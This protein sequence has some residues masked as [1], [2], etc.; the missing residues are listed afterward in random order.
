MGILGCS[1]CNQV[2]FYIGSFV[3]LHRGHEHIDFFLL[4]VTLT[5]CVRGN[6]FITMWD[7]LLSI[8]P[9]HTH[10]PSESH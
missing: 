4:K 2:K 7:T 9:P 6:G 3:Q 5:A 10:Y 1:S 8:Q